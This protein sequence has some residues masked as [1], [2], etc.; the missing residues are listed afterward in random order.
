MISYDRWTIVKILDIKLLY[1][2][3]EFNINRYTNLNKHI[4]NYYGK[5]GPNLE[6]ANVKLQ[7]DHVKNITIDKLSQI[8]PLRRVKRGI[9]N[10][11]GSIIKVITG[12][13]DNEDAIRY[14]K[15]INSMKSRQDALSKRFTLVA[16]VIESLVN[17]TNS[18][19]EN[20]VQLD[21]EIWEIR[22]LFNDTKAT[23]L[24]NKLISI[25]NLFLHNFLL[26]Y[27]R[28][29]EIET[30]LAVGRLR[31]LHQSVIDRGEL[32]EILR[33]IETR[34]KFVYP[35]NDKN[36]AKIEQ[37]VELKVYVKENKI[38]FLLEVPVIRKESFTYYRVL[39]LPSINSR[40]Q[41]T[42]VVPEH[43]FVLVKGLETLPVAQP[44]KEIDEDYFLCQEDEI[45]TLTEDRCIA[46]LMRFSTNTSSC[47][48]V[49]VEILRLRIESLHKNQWLIFTREHQILSKFCETEITRQ[50]IFGTYILTLDDNCEV[51][52][53]EKVLKQRQ[54][55]GKDVVVPKLPI[56][57]LPEIGIETTVPERKPLNLDGVSLGDLRLLQFALRQSES[58]IVEKGNESVV[59]MQ[60]ISVGTLVLYIFLVLS[61]CILLSVKY[62]TKFM[63]FQNHQAQAENHPPD[64][65]E[66]VRGGVMHPQPPSRHINVHP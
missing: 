16:E 13:L 37:C 21:K 57:N 18:T 8:V 6:L 36:L 12:N 63:C 42:L 56:I 31:T 50:S 20:F 19:R 52:I 49:P 55:R 5:T 62:Y 2:D 4:I 53:G 15:L 7:V 46:E 38:T 26:L 47:H 65:F 29:D 30:A 32:L 48:P 1:D 51:R 58:E 41:T 25:Y 14:D 66:L 22:K 35:V 54:I 9:L 45:V 24:A 61:F 60:S 40:N 3:L 17:V 10:P 28:F 59:N 44:C 34:D 64:D 33:A 27:I 23:Q 39:P 11:L 43:P